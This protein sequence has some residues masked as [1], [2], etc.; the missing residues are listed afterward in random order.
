MKTRMNDMDKVEITSRSPLGPCQTRSGSNSSFRSDSD[1][2]SSESLPPLPIS[3][4]SNTQVI[5]L[6]TSSPPHIPAKRPRSQSV[7]LISSEDDDRPSPPPRPAGKRKSRGGK[8]KRS[9]RRSPSVIIISDSDG[10]V[11]HAESKKGETEIGLAAELSVA[12]ES[13]VHNAESLSDNIPSYPFPAT[14]LRLYQS[15]PTLDE[16]VNAVLVDAEARRIVMRR[17]QKYDDD[18]GVKKVTVCCQCYQK[19]RETHN[20]AVHP[21]NQRRGRSNRTDCMAH[22]NINRIPGSSEYY[23]TLIQDTHNHPPTL[24]VGGKARRAPTAAQREVISRYATQ[25]NFNRRHVDFILSKESADRPL[26]LR[27]ISNII[28]SARQQARAEIAALGGDA[29]A[30]LQ[31]LEEL[32]D[33]DPRW[34]YRTQFGS[35]GTL[36]SLW[37]QSPEQAELLQEYPDVLINDCTYNRNQYGYP[38]NIGVGIDRL[39]HSRNLWYAFHAREDALTHEWVLRNHLDHAPRPPDVFASDH[40]AALE[41]VVPRLMPTT[42]HIVCLHHMEG[43]IKTNLRP[44]LGGD[45]DSFLKQFWAAYRAVSPEVFE[46]LWEQLLADFPAAAPYLSSNLYPIRHRWA[47]PWISCQFTAGIRTNGRVESENRTNK[48]LGGPKTSLVQ[49]FENLNQRTRDQIAKERITMRDVSDT[50]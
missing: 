1:Q 12:K 19:P 41:V 42:F 15:F 26:E 35:D 24:P 36:T 10:S 6:A 29:V 48:I 47:H 46:S 38:L 8:N 22:V 16:A 7:I 14:S 44:T 4:Q 23:L 21:G 40:D 9:R 25:G 13:E 28:T 39:G 49:L 18:A 33:D 2:A 45:W 5:H 43:N 34:R 30:V 20:P 27:Q 50:T 11:G 37:W 31:K 3:R 32:K 17:A